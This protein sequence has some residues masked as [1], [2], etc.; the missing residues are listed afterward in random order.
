MMSLRQACA[1]RS[2]KRVGV[3]EHRLL[4]VVLQAQHLGGVVN[5]LHHS[6]AALQKTYDESAASLC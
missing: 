6:Q 3:E 1:S 2:D 5:G 4:A